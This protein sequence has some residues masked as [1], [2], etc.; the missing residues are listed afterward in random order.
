MRIARFDAILTNPNNSLRS[1]QERNTL[2]LKN[3]VFNEKNVFFKSKVPANIEYLPTDK[4]VPT[5]LV[6]TG[7][8]PIYN[9]KPWLPS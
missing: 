9:Y 7:Y 4:P 6:K 8:L 1:E 2:R 5:K 3:Y